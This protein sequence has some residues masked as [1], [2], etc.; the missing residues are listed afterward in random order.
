M[1]LQELKPAGTLHF[2]HYEQLIQAAI[3]GEGVALGRTPLVK[4]LIRKRLLMAPFTGKTASSRQYFIVVSPESQQRADVQAFA[5]W[6][7]DEASHDTEAL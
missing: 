2:S 3:E 7:L 5:T 1:K 6:L 4:A